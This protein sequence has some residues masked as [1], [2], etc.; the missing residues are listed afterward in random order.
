[1]GYRYTTEDRILGG[2]MEPRLNPKIVER[3]LNAKLG[4]EKPNPLVRETSTGCVYENG[5]AKRR[6]VIGLPSRFDR[7]DY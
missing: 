6:S 3:Q 1:M 7:E 4:Y 5:Q 2:S